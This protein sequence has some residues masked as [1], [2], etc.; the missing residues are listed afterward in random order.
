MR[1]NTFFAIALAGTLVATT[2]IAEA[3]GPWR[4]TQ[5]NTAGW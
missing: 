1:N 2:G 3:R 4:A 5:M